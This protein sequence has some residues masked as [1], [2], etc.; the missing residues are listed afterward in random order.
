MVLL[1]ATFFPP[2]LLLLLQN[3]ETFLVLLMMLFLESS[4][5][6]EGGRML[7]L[8]SHISD[9]RAE[10]SAES[11]QMVT[12]Q[13]RG[14]HLP[15]SSGAAS[16]VTTSQHSQRQW[17]HQCLDTGGVIPAVGHF[18]ALLSLVWLFSRIFV[19][20]M[21]CVA[22][23]CLSEG[24]NTPKNSSTEIRSFSCHRWAE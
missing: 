3:K 22:M 2:S 19:L 5:A 24:K 9:T 10:L 4:T 17:F 18:P 16:S 11:F 8:C 21:Q 20:A 13:C 6:K 14:W 12:F 7:R 23:I 1:R 15:F